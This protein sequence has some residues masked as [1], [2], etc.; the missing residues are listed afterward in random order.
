MILTKRALDVHRFAK[1]QGVNSDG[2]RGFAEDHL[3]SLGIVAQLERM[4]LVQ[5]C[6][7]EALVGK[8]LFC[9]PVGFVV[10]KV[11]L[12]VLILVNAVDN[13]L[14]KQA[15]AKEGNLSNIDLRIKDLTANGMQ[16]MQAELTAANFGNVSDLAEKN[17][18]AR[19]VMNLV[20]E[21][22]AMCSVFAARS[23]GVE[24]I[25]LTGNLTQFPLC[26]EKFDQ[27]NSMYEGIHFSIPENAGFATVIGT[28][29]CGDPPKGDTG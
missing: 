4:L 28:A 15:L 25:V 9:E 14:H 12:I 8:L 10:H 18:I 2:F 19:G 24:E 5:L 27:I 22:I 26:K 20:Y 23:R 3:D 16:E 7:R 29:L 11:Q 6:F 17:D 13:S 21:T 1:G